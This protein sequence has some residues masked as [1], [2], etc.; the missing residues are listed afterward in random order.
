MSWERTQVP[1]QSGRDPL[2]RRASEMLPKVSTS[3]TAH[4]PRDKGLWFQPRED[5]GSRAGQDRDHPSA[6]QR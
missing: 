3:N 1:G 4:A 2:S 5:L 6:F